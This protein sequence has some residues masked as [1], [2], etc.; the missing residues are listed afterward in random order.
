[1]LTGNPHLYGLWT[2]LPQE[3]A[4]ESLIQHTAMGANALCRH[5]G[6]AISADILA[7]HGTMVAPHGKHNI[8]DK[9]RIAYII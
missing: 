5:L 9:Q 6:T 8:K 7:T 1:M 4:G 3:T 2:E